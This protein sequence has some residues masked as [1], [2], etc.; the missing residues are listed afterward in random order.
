MLRNSSS[1]ELCAEKLTWPSRWC[2]YSIG[3]I[4]DVLGRLT[5]VDV[6]RT[7]PKTIPIY[8]LYAVSTTRTAD[9]GIFFDTDSGHTIRLNIFYMYW[10]YIDGG[11]GYTGVSSSWR[12]MGNNRYITFFDDSRS[13]PYV[14]KYVNFNRI[15]GNS[16]AN[17]KTGYVFA[18]VDSRDMS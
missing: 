17:Y 15:A 4:V 10:G 14:D 1:A 3:T 11:S 16:P 8:G 12:S 2:G 6:T 18:L 9:C 13:N 7:F 5:R